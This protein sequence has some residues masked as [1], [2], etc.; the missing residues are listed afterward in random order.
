MYDEINNYYKITSYELPDWELSL[1]NNSPFFVFY[2]GTQSGDL[3]I[4]KAQELT[5]EEKIDIFFK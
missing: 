1:N 2:K 3:V 4:Q 5:D